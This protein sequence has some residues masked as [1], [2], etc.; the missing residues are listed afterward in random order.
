M[1][2][3]L[4]VVGCFVISS[5]EARIGENAIQ[6]ANRYGAPR[7]TPSSKTIDRN[8]PLVKGAIHHTYEYE[9][10]KIRAAFLNLNGPAIRMDFQKMSGTANGITIQNCE[11]EAIKTV[12][13]PLG[14]KWSPMA[15]DDGDSS[16]PGLAKSGENLTAVNQKMWRR[17]DGAILWLRS[18][19][20]VSLR[21]SAARAHEKQLRIRKDQRVQAS[22]P[23]F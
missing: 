5:A 11:F 4:L 6:C 14:M 2:R 16:K 8:S 1:R 20:I 21:L 12:N 10:W 17:S 15:Y 23:Q 9:G 18:N 7:D 22:V 19:L 13:T 3:F